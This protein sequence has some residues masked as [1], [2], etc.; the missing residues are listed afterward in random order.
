MHLFEFGWSQHIPLNEEICIMKKT[1]EDVVKYE[2]THTP[3]WDT[4]I[5]SSL[6]AVY[7]RNVSANPSQQQG[8][9]PAPQL[10]DNQTFASH[11][12]VNDRLTLN[13]PDS[14]DKC[15]TDIKTF[16]DATMLSE[17]L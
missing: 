6:R 3:Q 12:P 9:V 10:C 14:V 7:H 16:V 17:L 15:K 13:L 5:I 1:R 11:R 4:Q 8:P 2:I